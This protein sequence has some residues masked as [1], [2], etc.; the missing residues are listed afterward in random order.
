M[1]VDLV[2][3]ITLPI[4]I[5]LVF[6]LRRRLLMGWRQ[7]R[8]KLANVN[9]TL[10]ESPPIRVTKA[11]NREEENYRLFAEINNEHFQAAQKVVPLSGFFWSSVN[12]VN[13]LG[14]VLI[15]GDRRSL[16]HYGWVTLGVLAAF[17]NYVNRLF[18]PIM[19]LEHPL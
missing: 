7:I 8:K 3:L 2:T 10:N 4:I 15:P 18:Q 1:A 5:W 14:T 12:L 16:L 11:F 13:H 19:N 9:A 6:M 17:M